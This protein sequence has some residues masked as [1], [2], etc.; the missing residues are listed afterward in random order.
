M[1]NTYPKAKFFVFL[2]ILFFCLAC[3]KRS[4]GPVILECGRG[5]DFGCPTGMFCELKS[6]CGGFDKI[7]TCVRQPTDCP[8]ETK[9]VCGCDGR[10]YASACYARASGVTINYEGKCIKDN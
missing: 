8:N 5:A 7:G 3:C 6:E 4:K 10:D 2:A 9:P 1:S